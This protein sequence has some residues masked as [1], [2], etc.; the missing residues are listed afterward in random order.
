MER[1]LPIGSLVVITIAL[2]LATFMQVLDTSIANVVLPAIAGNFGVS[3]NQAT[4]VITSFAASN[5]I[6]LPL[7]G[8]FARRFGEVKTFVAATA[9]FTVASWLCGLATSLPM[10]VFFRVVQGAVAGPMIPLSQSL[11]LAN[12]PPHLK[13]MALALTSMTVVVAPIFGPIVGGWITDNFSWPWIFYINIPI[14]AVSAYVSFRML[15]RREAPTVRVPIDAIGFALLVIGVGCLQVLLDKGNE[16]DWFDSRLIIALAVIAVAALSYFVAWELTDRHP[17]VDLT[18][19][20]GRNFAVGTI[21][22][23][24][25]FLVLFASM[26]IFPLW[27]Q[28]QLGYTATWAGFAIAPIGFMTLILSPIVGRTL[29]RVDPRL[30]ASASFLVFALAMFW[31]ASFTSQVSFDQL[32]VPR[33]IMGLGVAFFFPALIM[34]Q[35]AGM[36]PARIASALGLANFMRVLAGSFGA[37]LSIALWD[38]REAL[39][40]SQLAEHI[41]VYDPAGLSALER[42]RALGMGDNEALAQIVRAATSQAYMLAINDVF[43][44]SAW[45]FLALFCAVWFSRPPFVAGGLAGPGAH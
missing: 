43:L 6:A 5:A 29:H 27:L 23:S 15:H 35:I 24:G 8:W 37:S 4:W 14:G 40:F 21:A 34:I 32:V 1:P 41:S 44:I 13:G 18:L 11:L 45:I 31:M 9:L 20:K 17:V 30:Y 36:D 33:L 16:L 19:F 28:T 22:A 2:P 7:T 3:P 38:R 12:Y 39:H 25:G 10:L 26:V 42:M